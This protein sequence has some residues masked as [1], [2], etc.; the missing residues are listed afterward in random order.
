MRSK[1]KILIACLEQCQ[2]QNKLPVLA[3]LFSR[4]ILVGGLFCDND[5]SKSRFKLHPQEPWGQEMLL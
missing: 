3:D 5:P 1:D 2:A 4:I